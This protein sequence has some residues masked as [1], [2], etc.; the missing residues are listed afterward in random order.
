MNEIS[1]K[2]FILK[3]DLKPVEL[4]NDSLVTG[5]QSIYEVIR[6]VKGQP[7]FFHDHMDRLVNSVY[8]QRKKP[9]ASVTELRRSIL[10]LIKSDR[11][12]EANLKIVFNYTSESE[13]YLVYYIKHSY[14]TAE[15]Y[16]HGVKGILHFAERKDPE[17]KV[18]NHALRSSIKQ[19]LI[20][21]EAYEAILV[22][23][24]N[25]ITE[26]SKSNIF[27]LSDDTLFTAP[28]DIILNGITRKHVLA[29][30]R[31]HKIKYELKCVNADDISKYEAVFITGTSPMVLPLCCIG[32]VKFNTKL[33]LM[34]ELRKLYSIKAR[35]SVALF[36]PE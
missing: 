13:N 22:N 21:E 9:L 18:I 14:P 11:R 31:E 25:L 27:F 12:K 20:Q 1:G 8:L 33:P 35:E 16:K 6:L 19:K 7:V 17:S 28:D 26:G 3:G 5:G 23:E 4:F 30:C 36:S 24:N 32:E 29:I 34:E 2:K 15:Q 10:K